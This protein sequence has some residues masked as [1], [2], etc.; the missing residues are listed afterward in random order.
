VVGEDEE[1]VVAHL[2]EDG[3]RLEGIFDDE[4]Q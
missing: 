4:W 1:A 2:F 3:E